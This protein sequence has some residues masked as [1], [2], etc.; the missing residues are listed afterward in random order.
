MLDKR[1]F[2]FVA[3]VLLFFGIILIQQTS[4]AQSD[5][6]SGVSQQLSI[7]AQGQ[8]IP[9]QSRNRVRSAPGG[10]Q[11]GFVETG[12]SF[13]VIDGPLC[14]D[15]ISWWQVRTQSGIIGWTAE[16]VEGEAFLE[17]LILD[18]PSEDSSEQD[19]ANLNTSS[20]TSIQNTDANCDTLPE[21]NLGERVFVSDIEGIDTYYGNPELP[22][23]LFSI[24]Q[25]NAYLAD[26]GYS[27]P[28]L[29]LEDLTLYGDGFISQGPVCFNGEYFWKVISGQRHIFGVTDDG[30]HPT[31]WI[32]DSALAPE[33]IQIPHQS[34]FQPEY[35][36]LSEPENAPLISALEQINYASGGGGGNIPILGWTVENCDVGEMIGPNTGFV[37]YGENRCLSLYPF[38]SADVVTIR[39]LQPDGTLYS[40]YQLDPVELTATKFIGLDISPDITA[41]VTESLSIIGVEINIPTSIGLPAGVWIIEAI[42]N[43]NMIRAAYHLQRENAQGLHSICD[44]ALMQYWVANYPPYTQLDAVMYELTSTAIEFGETREDFQEIARWGINTGADGHA[45]LRGGLIRNT[46][47]ILAITEPGSTETISAD[48]AEVNFSRTRTGIIEY[49]ENSSPF[50]IIAAYPSI[51]SIETSP[52]SPFIVTQNQLYTNTLFPNK[53][54]DIYEFYNTEESEIDIKWQG[55]DINVQIISPNG[56]VL[57]SSTDDITITLLDSGLYQLI[58]ETNSELTFERLPYHFILEIEEAQT[59]LFNNPITDILE[60]TSNF[61]TFYGEQGQLISIEVSSINFD[62][63]I[64]LLDTN[65]NLLIEDDDSGNGIDARVTDFIL[66]MTGL[67]TIEVTAWNN[68]SGSYILE[69]SR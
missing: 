53:T 51:C 48:R 11:I 60:S 4:L 65:E 43:N 58:F 37:R 18:V 47:L 61:H 19:L 7:G 55:T 69:L 16:G 26:F 10:E 36:L 22:D 12:E 50:S 5:C 6:G 44:G 54:R 42:Q 28:A 67:Y 33:N 57:L 68:K 20:L 2:S 49:D 14:Q 15:N 8:V 66:P 41:E 9:G 64:R 40:E 17:L 56:D 1:I 27:V 23:Q 35:Y 21:R 62:S 34:A 46:N 3:F 52:N 38:N 45:V 24:N 32:R 63:Q 25:L 29:F 39:I 31:Y 30:I 13:D 59:L